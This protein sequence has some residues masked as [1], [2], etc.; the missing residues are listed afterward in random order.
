MLMKITAHLTGVAANISHVEVE[1]RKLDEK[2]SANIPTELQS[3]ATSL[4]KMQ[5]LWVG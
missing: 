5:D 3:I 2:S 1:Y 4:S